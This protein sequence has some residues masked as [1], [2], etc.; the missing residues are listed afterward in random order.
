MLLT[1]AARL[2]FGEAVVDVAAEQADDVPDLEA[3]GP[4]QGFLG[5]WCAAHPSRV[6]RDDVP[7]HG[8]LPQTAFGRRRVF[9]VLGMADDV[10]MQVVDIFLPDA[11]LED[12]ATHQLLPQLPMERPDHIP[13]S[14]N[15]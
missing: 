8:V 15:S 5:T 13:S 1:A 10:C 12:G 7:G 9:A 14:A 3:V 6:T 11:T 4:G 2:L